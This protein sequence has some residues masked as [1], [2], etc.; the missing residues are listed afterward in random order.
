MIL[1]CVDVVSNV[2]IADDLLFS[3]AEA[4]PANS[5]H[6]PHLT[7]HLALGLSAISFVGATLTVAWL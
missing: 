2:D 6:V 4:V 3:F 1:A 7:T 5:S